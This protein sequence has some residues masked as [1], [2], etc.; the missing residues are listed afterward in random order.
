[1]SENINDYIQKG[2]YGTRQSK[3]DERRLFLGSLRERAVFVLIND[4][5]IQEQGVKELEQ[6]MIEHPKAQLLFNGHLNLKQLNPYRQIALKHQFNY[7][8]VEEK[9]NQKAYGIVLCYDHAVDA[10][11]I[12]LK[13]VETNQQT[14]HASEKKTSLWQRWFGTGDL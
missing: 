14:N 12:Y 11:H 5:V 2:V 10:D 3:P 7:S 13:E 9:N 1:M 8:I 6:K 4:Q